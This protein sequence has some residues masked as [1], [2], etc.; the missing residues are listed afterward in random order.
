MTYSFSFALTKPVFP[1]FC[2]VALQLVVV[3]VLIASNSASQPV[4]DDECSA[5]DT[6]SVFV[7]RSMLKLV[8][9][10]SRPV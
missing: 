10:P 8:V 4:T 6:V 3:S 1:E 7:M 2:A 9:T 5:G